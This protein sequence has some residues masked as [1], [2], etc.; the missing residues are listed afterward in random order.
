MTRLGVLDLGS[1]T[2]HLLIVD[3]DYASKRFAEVFRKRIFIGLSKSGLVNIPSDRIL[4]AKAAI[5]TFHAHCIEYDVKKI[6]LVG[7]SIFRRAKNI[8]PLIAYCYDTFGEIVEIVDGEREGRL[9][10]EGISFNRRIN[11]PSL[12]MDIGGGS[13]EWIVYQNKAQI[14]VFSFPIGVGELYA[15]FHKE[16]P[17]S[18]INIQRAKSY[19]LE[20][21]KPFFEFIEEIDFIEF[22]GT[23]GPFEIVKLMKRSESLEYMVEKEDFVLF[24]NELLSMNRAERLYLPG[25]PEERVDLTVVAVILI[26][27]V[28]EYARVDHIFVVPFGIKEGVL[29]ELIKNEL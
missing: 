23:S 11:E 7:T 2:F 20:V 14:E 29:S 24:S 9:I 17:I 26:S 12:I 22:I 4:N 21:A 8:Q 1:N 27:I 5:R 13:V 16:E 10:L 18:K 28:L 25:M 6:K 15:R 19:I 3:Y